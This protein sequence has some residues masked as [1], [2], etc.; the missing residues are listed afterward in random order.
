MLYLTN[1]YDGWKDEFTKHV[2]RTSVCKEKLRSE[3]K[4]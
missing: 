4:Y 2:M 3:P 1:Y